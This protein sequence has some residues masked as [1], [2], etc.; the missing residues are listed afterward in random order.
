MTQRHASA[1]FT[2]NLHN[3]ADPWTAL[4]TFNAGIDITHADGI[5]LQ[6][7]ETI[8]NSTNGLIS[9]SGN[10]A[11]P[12]GGTIGS[13]SDTD[14]ITIA[15][16]GAVTFSQG[17]TS[18]AAANA[19]GASSI[20]DD[21]RLGIGTG[22][23]TVLVNR[24]TSLG[25]NVE[26]SNVIV[27]TSNH[28]GVAANSLILSNITTD[29]DIQ[30]L[31]SDGGDSLEAININA[32]SA[33]L[34]L[35]HG[36]ADVN[37]KTAGV[38]KVRFASAVTTFNRDS[39]NISF[40][41]NSQ[42]LTAISVAGDTGVVT[43]VG[44]IDLNETGELLNVGAPNND[45]TQNAFKLAGGTAAQYMTIETTGS[46]VDAGLTL[47]I[48]ASGTGGCDI[49]YKQGS[50]DGTANNQ[51]Y[52]QGYNGS[53][54]YF[55]LRSTNTDDD[56][57]GGAT[58][59]DADI[60]RVLDGTQVIKLLANTT[61]GY[62][63]YDDAALLETS[64]SPTAKAYD[65]GRGIFK[66]G[67]EALIEVGVLERFDDG[68]VGYDGQRMAALLAGGIY[69]TRAAVATLEERLAALEARGG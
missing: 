60:F 19:L 8:K 59:T 2:K 4:Q 48:P 32:A 16:A 34:Q 50:G 33:L 51:R 41:V 54:G 64:F 40:V 68:W 47:I 45:W 12:D 36:M 10:L 56:F 66:Q 49:G 52:I 28:Q 46:A 1:R 62:D 22:F 61:T 53:A 15:S 31:V 57:G 69:Q 23:D 29:G 58:G 20:A 30:V 67:Q 24:S 38:E 13:A 25:A 11:I 14:A 26:L 35:G 27:G 43:F 37:I 65:F 21:V 55:R 7:D 42:A 5:T 17:V 3:V 6:N 18:T 44:D 9:L 39:G 63:D